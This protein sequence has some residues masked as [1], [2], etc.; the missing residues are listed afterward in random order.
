MAADNG[1]GASMAGGSYEV[2]RSRLVATAKSLGEKT[3]ALNTRRRNE[4]GGQELTV[5]ATERVRTEH[6]CVPRDIVPVRG[7]L[8]LGFNVF[9]GLKQD[10]SVKD[11]FSLHKF[12]KG[13]DGAFDFSEVPRST[14]G[15]FLEDRG[16]VKDFEELYRFYKDARLNHMEKSEARLLITFKTGHTLRDVKVLRFGVDTSDRLTYLDNR[17]DADV[18]TPP[19]HDFEYKRATRENFVLG[20]HPHVNILDELFI[21]TVGGDLTI[22]IE[23]NTETGQGIYAEP[24]H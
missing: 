10:R 3:N 7:H 9:M 8:L 24:V 21:E 22:K 14:D 20:R 17:G 1:Q 6:N 15:G 23:N 13:A 12:G 11:V 18:V 2:I 16:F 5:L 19:T 4:F